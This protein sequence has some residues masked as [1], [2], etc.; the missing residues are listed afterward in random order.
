MVKP[1]GRDAAIGERHE[2]QVAIGDFLLDADARLEGDATAAPGKR[3]HQAQRIAFK[4]T[5]RRDL[6][7]LLQFVE[8]GS[9]TQ[10][11][12][13]PGHRIVEAMGEKNLR[14]RAKGWSRRMTAPICISLTSLTSSPS[15]VAGLKVKPMIGIVIAHEVGY[16]VGTGDSHRHLHTRMICGEVSQEIGECRDRDAF[17]CRD[18]DAA[19]LQS[20]QGIEMIERCLMALHHGFE[21][22]K[23]DLARGRQPQATATPLEQGKIRTGARGG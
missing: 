3:R 4:S 11:A 17:D 16:G 23:Q 12:R 7:R 6:R 20:A 18:P 19:A 14:S 15:S 9:E 2:D 13:R 5:R 21:T 1:I 22:V 10:A 8:D